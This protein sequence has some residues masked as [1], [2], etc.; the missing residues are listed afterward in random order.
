MYKALRI[1]I[2][3]GI[4]FCS[5]KE[6]Y[7]QVN[8][9]FTADNTTGCGTFVVNFSNQST[10][11]GTLN[12]NWDFGN[13]NVS[14]QTNPSALYSQPG[15]YTVTLSVTNGVNADQVVQVD[16][17]TVF[18]LPQPNFTAN[19]T[20]GCPP[21]SVAF[22]NSSVPGS[23]PVDS[24][25]WDF[26][27]GNISTGTA[28]SHIYTQSGN[29]TV[30]MLIVDD[31]GCSSN[32]TF[33]NAIQVNTNSPTAGFTA[34]DTVLCSAPFT[35]NFTN[36]SSGTGAI[37]YVW[38][39]GDG[40]TSAQTNPSH[41]YSASGNYTVTLTATYASGC[42]DVETKTN[43]I[44]AVGVTNPNFSASDTTVCAGVG[45]V[46]TN[47]TNPSP[48][49]VLWDFGDGTTSTLANPIHS[50]PNPG[51]YTVTLQN[52]YGSNCN[53]Q[54]VKTNYI[55]VSESP[56]ANFTADVT[57]ACAP[58]LTVNFT[59]QSTGTGP[60]T[61]Q[62]NLGNGSS[63]APD[64]TR[65]YN[66]AGVFDVRL[67]VANPTG[68]RDT[69]R[70]DEYIV[71]T[72]PTVDL[73]VGSYYPCVPV[74]VAFI[75][76][77]TGP[78][79]TTSWL[80]NF[81][82]G[83]TSTQQNPLHVYAVQGSYQVSLSVVDSMG[84]SGTY[85]YP[86]LISSFT[87]P[88][89]DFSTLDQTVC[90]GTGTQMN[91]LSTNSNQ[92]NWIVDGLSSS[93]DQNPELSFEDTGYVS[94]GLIAS[95]NGCMDTLVR[96][97][98]LY[99]LAPV[100]RFS[101]TKDCTAPLTVFFND[102]SILPDSYT[103]DFGDGS[104]S[105]EA[106]PSHTYAATGLYTVLHT[107]TNNA[108][109][110]S[111]T[112][113][114]SLN[115]TTNSSSFSATTP[116]TGCAPL[117]V[118]FQVTGTGITNRTWDFG[119][120]ST[121]TGASPTH[122]YTQPGTYDVTVIVRYGSTCRDTLVQQAMV[123]VSGPVASFSIDTV[124]TCDSVIAS[125][126]GSS[127]STI[128]A[129]N[130]NFG[131]GSTGVGQN[132]SHVY[133]TS[134]TFPI[135][136]TVE[137]SGGC[138]GSFTQTNGVSILPL[139]FPDFSV[140]DS[141]PC[142]GQVID[143]QRQ[144]SSAGITVLWDFGDG[145]TSTAFSPTH[146][147]QN[148]G[149]YTV[150]LTVTNA[151]G[152][153]LTNVQTD[154]IAIVL[155]VINFTAA[156]TSAN[157]PPLLASFTDQS[158]PDVVSW[159][160]DFGDGTS[161]IIQNPG[162]LFVTSGS[163]PVSL[164]VVNTN[165][166]TD[167]L[168]LDSLISVNGP[169][170]TFS[171]DPD[172]L[173]CPPYLITFTANAQNTTD[174]TW[175]FGDGNIGTGATVTHLYQNLGSFLPGLLLENANTGCSF[176]VT[177]TD[178]ITIAPL[179][180]DAGPDQTICFGQTVQLLASGGTGYVW[181]PNSFLTSDTIYN[182]LAN[183]SDTI[184]YIVTITKGLCSN[185]DTVRIFVKPAPVADF[186]SIP[187][188]DGIPVQFNNLSQ[189]DSLSSFYDWDFG[190]V[191][192]SN[193]T[194]PSFLFPGFGSYPVRLILNSQNGCS[195]TV[196][197]S[198]VV[199]AVPDWQ[200]TAQDVCFGEG[201]DFSGNLTIGQGTVA[202][203]VWDFGDG[204][205]QTALH[206]VYTYSS[207]DTF[208]VVTIA[209]SDQGCT[210]TSRLEV[211]VNPLP[212]A[213]FTVENVCLRDSSV[214]VDVSTIPSGA[215]SSWSWDFGDGSTESVQYPQHLY[216]VDSSYVVQLIV[217]SQFG[218]T[219]TL[220]QNHIVRPLPVPR[221]DA[222]TDSSCISPVQVDFTNQ[223][224][225]AVQYEWTYGNGDL[226]NTTQGQVTYDSVGDY[227]IQ[228]TAV[229]PFGCRDS[230]S[231]TYSV[232]PTPLAN[233]TVSDP[234]GCEPFFVLFNNISQ[235][236][237]TYS[238]GFGD[239][240]NSS[241]VQPFHV[242]EQPGIYSINLTVTGLG[243]CQST[244]F[245]PNLIRVLAKPMA[246]FSYSVQTVPLIDGTVHFTNQSVDQISSFWDLGDGST[247]NVNDT[248]P[249]RYEFWGN[250]EIE[251]I[252]TAANG[253]TDT[254]RRTILVDFF[255]GLFVP[256]ALILDGDGETRIFLPKGKGLKNYRLTIWDDWGNLIFESRKLENG[257]PSEGW[258]GYYKGEPVPLDAY[259][260]KIEAEFEDGNFWPG[261]EVKPSFYKDAGSVT[262]IR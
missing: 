249:H 18:S 262:V 161:S 206:P 3:L 98:F 115:I 226:G 54:I 87:K 43:Y 256:N 146:A 134:G 201:V 118:S 89:A 73:N 86:T 229:S 137:E 260:W 133:D 47:L 196:F 209:T 138:T 116:T 233:F 38:D 56:V 225:G 113:T 9:A 71:T 107:V 218:C 68:C 124:F 183:P 151:N 11:S 187:V 50:Y 197:H 174:Y 103:W 155:P 26:G 101:F 85:V 100:N 177:S 22:T 253:C 49:S 257:M 6:A 158:S 19:P 92:W 208:Q 238:W 119:D 239:G 34:D 181:T 246:D 46:F 44:T 186:N 224:S 143:F 39:F 190:N 104:T 192:T 7:S 114:L 96:D 236:A 90:S 184:D 153:Q 254:L 252:V 191:G 142:P 245:S 194:N 128:I 202:S 160:W 200:A 93:T 139:P 215:I 48:N 102:T 231:Q 211:I 198:A 185:S 172:T 178:S 62:W 28:L 230:I 77:T 169:I 227:S 79:P 21:L 63:N 99:L 72:G 220:V 125:F 243:G 105:T 130:W 110:C 189:N 212:I 170:G 20:A 60:L 157:C 144:F 163:F 120:G 121:S 36:Q 240:E 235:N 109:G 122:V 180:V 154:I 41:T 13:G 166:C 176:T 108:T 222:T 32:Q 203:V 80:W 5:N 255:G 12:Y 42:S 88:V 234:I 244:L 83:N 52:V 193:D 76:Q 241:A 14:T 31:N 30:S 216:T 23:A 64:P 159:Q 127:T 251:L 248:F 67:I 4:L 258:N 195:D 112:D 55:F 219:D 84:C 25:I 214:F 75:D 135:T 1:F 149:N 17:I 152:C 24:V 156:P 10:G 129:W 57:H 261:K 179:P 94:V 59:N 61:Y 126:Q 205:T 228:L 223:S 15:T 82:D 111:D 16:Y 162:H 74:S 95:N 217:S 165:G 40:S 78:F 204:N 250:K 53:D 247:S 131:D 97:S 35:V 168:T 221:F 69:L 140:S 117:S 45:V 173:G 207:T 167:S 27:D 199:F 175:D 148:A 37:N 132:I 66:S 2:F 70:R 65:T 145:T 188:C 210:D 81:G 33:P 259:F 182:P 150:S 232:Y 136:L 8:A 106:D 171:T 29:Y 141:F 91:N 123:V 213:N 164:T 58:P 147:Y 51:N 237:L 242:F